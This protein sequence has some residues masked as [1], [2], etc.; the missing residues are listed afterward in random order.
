[1]LQASLLS[2]EGKAKEADAALAAL[3]AGDAAQAADAALMRAQL[4]AAGGDA[5]GALRHLEVSRSGGFC[6][7]LWHGV[8]CEVSSGW[9][10]VLRGRYGA[11]E[12]VAL[13]RRA[14]DSLTVER[15]PQAGASPPSS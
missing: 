8:N 4:A 9:L 12:W 3:A 1:M 5:A 14:A 2:R 11:W 10:G 7:C 15:P 6:C 13:A